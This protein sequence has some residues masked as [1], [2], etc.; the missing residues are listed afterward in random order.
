MFLGYVVSTNGVSIDPQK[1]KAVVIWK[2]HTTAMK[3][4]SFLSLVGY[5]KC[6]VEDFSKLALP[7][8]AVT[9]KNAKFQWFEKFEQS[10]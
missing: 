1:I 3:V 7:L 10:L 9:R 5:Y 6:F 4:R 2:R 8:I